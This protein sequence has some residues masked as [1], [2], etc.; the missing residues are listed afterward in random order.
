M[1]EPNR[2]RLDFGSHRA[3]P[4]HEGCVSSTQY[5]NP[6]C[7]AGP[8]QVYSPLVRET[9]GDI[10]V[11]WTQMPFFDEAFWAQ[12]GDSLNDIVDEYK[13]EY[14]EHKEGGDT[15]TPR[16]G[17]CELPNKTAEEHAMASCAVMAKGLVNW[18]KKN[19]ANDRI[20][21]KLSLKALPDLLNTKQPVTKM[22]RTIN[23]NNSIVYYVKNETLYEQMFDKTKE[24][25][26]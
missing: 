1:A 22:I 25:G 9:P 3:L 11:N 7:G 4:A 13:D 24:N 18:I 8:E 12:Q 5:Q 17:L 10:P 23:A 21:Q 2:F 26:T 6:D 19:M 15:T 14:Q 16:R 20:R